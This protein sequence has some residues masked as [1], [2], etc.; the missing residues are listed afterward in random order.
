MIPELKEVS[1]QLVDFLDHQSRVPI[2]RIDE[3]HRITAC[4]NGFLELF[5]LSEVPIGANLS[6]FLIS[7][8]E[9]IVSEEG[10]QEFRFNPQTRVQGV[11]VAHR[12]PHKKGLLLWFERPFATDNRVVETMTLMN[13][14]LISTQREL[15]K[16]NHHLNQLK[17]E[18]AEKVVLLQESDRRYS[19]L[20]TNKINGMAHCRVITDEH[21]RPVNYQILQINTAFERIVGIKKEDI[22]GRRIKDVFPGI[23]DL[24]FDYIGVLGKIAL[25]GGEI[26]TEVFFEITQKHLSLYAYCPMPGEF[27]VILTD[28][29]DRKRTEAALQKSE[30]RLSTAARA[31]DFGVYSYEFGG[32]QAYYSPEFLALF[33][34]PP[35]ATLELDEDLIAKAL[36]PD[37]KPDFLAF[38]KAASDPCGSGILN[39][40]YRII[41]PDGQIRWLRVTG[42]TVFS[43]KEPTDRPIQAYGISRDITERKKAEQ[44]LKE[45]KE[46][47]NLIL[48]S[49][50]EG[51]YGID[52]FGCCTFCNQA[53]LDLLGYDH[54]EELLGKNMHDLIHHTLPDG[55]PFPVH[56]CQIFKAF[57]QGEGTHV[58]DEVL[59]RKN[60]SSFP[61]EYWSFPQYKGGECI[62]AVVTFFDITARKQVEEIRAGLT[63]QIQILEKTESLHRMAGAIAYTFNN[64]LGATMGYLEIAMEDL[65]PE[66]S[67][68]KYLASAFQATERAVEVSSMMLTYLGQSFS[69]HSKLCLDLSEVCRSSLP[70]LENLIKKDVIL[71]A[72]LPSP[73]PAI[74]ANTSHIQRLIKNLV[75][76]A[77]EAIQDEQGTITVVI[78]TVSSV[79]LPTVH[80]F[81]VDWQ[82][83]GELFACLMVKDTGSGIAAQ[84]IDKL[85]DPFFTSKFA[86]RGLGLAIILGIL[87]MHKGMIT[88]ESEPGHGSVFQVFLPL[89]MEDV[90]LEQA[91]ST[92]G[93]TS[94][95]SHTVLLI[96]DEQPMREMLETMLARLGF[97]V[98]AARDGVEAIDIFREHQKDIHIVLCDITMSG[99][100]GWDTLETLRTI[101]P[102]IQAI[103][104][105]GHDE[106]L[107][108]QSEKSECPQAFLQ[109]PF[110]RQDL[111]RTLEAALQI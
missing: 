79:D 83:Q 59:W 23:E 94:E 92:Q 34:L 78:K 82:P 49:A 30:E 43:G 35:D 11:L 20:F 37:D 65:P 108:M 104:I 109:K 55:S 87:K 100:D 25:E 10:R 73:G 107:V 56:N 1:E 51:I 9:E 72:D 91:T 13:N 66:G 68:S 31:A 38:V 44:Q 22:E 3:Q 63:K 95:V 69:E 21:G 32:G 77:S 62:G 106:A 29:A 48:N 27:T 15:V 50:A 71:A 16:K 46:M 12:L 36:H 33:G 102:T 5:C 111:Q 99:M 40:E 19:A 105:S 28:I 54:Q 57:H 84:D 41:L 67:L 90:S 60:G 61:A 86:G 14:E 39:L 45:R 76:N 18:L 96:E 101:V 110:K 97:V 53:S 75:I 42:Q 7:S 64:L 98:F 85:F 103:F 70:M 4:N 6:D 8:D 88:V 17:N 58:D 93:P 74:I 52:M 26:N 81:P 24:A 2:L 89:S 80:R 47:L